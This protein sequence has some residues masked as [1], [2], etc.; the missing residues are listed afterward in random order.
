M[1]FTPAGTEQV[2]VPGVEYEPLVQSADKAGRL[3]SSESASTK[4]L[5]FILIIMITP[6]KLILR[7]FSTNPLVITIIYDFHNKNSLLK[8]ILHD[9]E[10]CPNKTLDSLVNHY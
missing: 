3:E 1:E 5:L 4:L 10:T 2:D 6:K 9:T 7:F 8:K